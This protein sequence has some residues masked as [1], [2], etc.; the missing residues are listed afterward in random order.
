MADNE[1][2]LFG[3]LAG[4][5]GDLDGA[6]APADCNDADATIRPG[7]TDV[8]DNGIDEDCSGADTENLDRDADGSP[9]PADCNDANPSV[10]PGAADVTDNGLD[11]DCSG[12]DAVNLDRDRDGSLRP[13]DCNDANAPRSAPAPA[14]PRATAWTRTARARTPRFPPRRERQQHLG[15]ST[16]LVHPADAI[17]ALSFRA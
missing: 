3:R 6:V 9:R 10:R 13:V 12:A 16:A 5:D 17:T 8:I 7:A 2:E 11:E 15:T 1:F 4:D 14:T